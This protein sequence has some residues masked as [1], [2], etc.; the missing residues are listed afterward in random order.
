MNNESSVFFLGLFS[1]FIVVAL[2][3]SMYNIAEVKAIGGAFENADPSMQEEMCIW[4]AKGSLI[5]NNS[6]RK[7]SGTYEEKL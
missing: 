2:S 4:A 3:I 7:L 6:C 5:A 1:F